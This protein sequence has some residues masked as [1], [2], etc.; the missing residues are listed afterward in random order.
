MKI[1]TS[2]SFVHYIME[3]AV[4][5]GDFVVDATTTNGINTRF[6]A[7][8]V[9]NEGEVIS[10]AESKENANALAAS[11]F[12]SGLEKRVAIIGKKY[13]YNLK[14]TYPKTHFALGIWDY[15]K[16]AEGTLAVDLAE[17]VKNLDDFLVLLNHGGL[18]I[19]KLDKQLADDKLTNYLDELFVD[20]Y[21]TA[22]YLTDETKTFLISRI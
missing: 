21:K 3:N 17:L 19:I 8:R 22:V 6:L 1:P 18:A 11:L 9:G 12:M 10:Y 14:K 5:V 4:K 15:S 16:D 7:S 13:D 2:N 20:D